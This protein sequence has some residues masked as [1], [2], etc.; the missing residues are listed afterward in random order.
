MRDLRA[1]RT[2][3]PGPA[4][5]GVAV[6]YCLRANIENVHATEHAVGFHI[7]GVARS[8]LLRCEAY[9]T[10][11]GAP[12]GDVFTGFLLE[13]D[14]RIGFAGGNASIY[15]TD[16]FVKVER[17]PPL[18]RI[19]GAHLHG[20]FADSFLTR[21][22]TAEVAQGILVEGSAADP[23]RER[24]R[25]GNADLHIHLP[26]LD[27]CSAA[28]LT[29][30]G[31]TDYAAVDIVDPYMA[32]TAAALAAIHLHDN[33]GAI[34]IAGGQ[35]LGPGAGPASTIGIHITDA[36]GFDVRGTKLRGF[37]RPV[38]VTRARDFSLDVAVYNPEQ[39]AIQ[40]AVRLVAC[41]RATVRARVT[42]RARAFPAGIH[43]E[44][45]TRAVH[46]DVTGISPA[47]L[48][49]PALLHDAAAITRPGPFGA[50]TASGVFAG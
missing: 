44:A 40:A 34:T 27:G 23:D 11:P 17:A 36:S 6:R 4:A 47:A 31:L 10:L 48:S 13:G 28:C 21:F 22:E 29:I 18:T 49:G 1:E 41:E 24:Q 12:G 7:G 42:G 43:L 19:I 9:R 32:P 33:A 26:V 3:P 50:N 38:G 45:G 39:T 25:T 46:A 8:F 2:A 35:L 14:T 30:S 16:C 37:V 20:A 15:L 5:V